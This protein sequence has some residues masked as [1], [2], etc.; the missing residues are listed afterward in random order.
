MRLC[1][2]LEKA[3]SPRVEQAILRLVR[4]G[5]KLTPRLVSEIRRS[6]DRARDRR[7]STLVTADL[8]S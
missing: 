4:H 5:S 6:L 7:L 3:G 2:L 8:V 1:A